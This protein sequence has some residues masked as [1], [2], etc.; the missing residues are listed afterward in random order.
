MTACHCASQLG[1][2][3]LLRD[4]E[5]LPQRLGAEA[6]IFVHEP[7]PQDGG[8]HGPLQ[9]EA[10]VRSQL[11]AQSQ[12]ANCYTNN[13]RQLSVYVNIFSVIVFTLFL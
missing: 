4:E 12:T 2:I 13:T 8:A 5:M 11:I 6:A 7:S 9:F 3:C 1:L 10:K